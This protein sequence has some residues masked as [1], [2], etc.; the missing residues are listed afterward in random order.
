MD[1]QWMLNSVFGL[2]GALGGFVLK[3]TWDALSALQKDM[4][5]LQDKISNTYVRRDDFRDH[6]SKLEAVLT[7]IERK[8]DEKQDKGHS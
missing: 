7:R 4:A 3:A 5:A 6:A 1:P 2:A 8:L